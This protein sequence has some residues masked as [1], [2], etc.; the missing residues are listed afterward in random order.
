[1]ASRVKGETQAG[2]EEV[3]YPFVVG[4][5]WRLDLKFGLCIRIDATYI[6]MKRFLEKPP[7]RLDQAVYKPLSSRRMAIMIPHYHSYTRIMKTIANQHAMREAEIT[8]APAT[9]PSSFELGRKFSMVYTAKTM[10]ATKKKAIA[11][12]YMH[13]QHSAGSASTAP[14]SGFS[15][16][17]IEL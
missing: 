5:A 4:L 11:H 10:S 16:S 9:T 13:L 17:A 1:M 3:A 12:V 8:T 14:S 7:I 6:L 2:D 15:T